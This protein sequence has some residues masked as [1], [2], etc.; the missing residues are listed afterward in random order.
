M[1]GTAAEVIRWLTTQDPTKVWDIKRHSQKRSL[2]QNAYF[3][4]LIGKM[5]D[6]L[7]VSKSEVHNRMLR[8]YGQPMGID[9]RLVTVALPDTETAEKKALL[10]ETV[11]LKPTSQ[12]RCGTKNQLFR[13]YVM[14]RGSH[15]LNTDEMAILLDG[16]INEAQGLGVETLTPY[17]RAMLR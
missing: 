6:V 16:T 17:E 5:A 2:S 10:M 8:A 7:R 4:V 12:V 11:H 9:G 13:T 1:T 14:L 3:H 15:E